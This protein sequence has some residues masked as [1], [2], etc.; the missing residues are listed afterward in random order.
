MVLGEPE[1]GAFAEAAMVSHELCGRC[2][3]LIL[4]YQLADSVWPEALAGTVDT[5]SDRTVSISGG[6]VQF[7]EC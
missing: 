7:G 2:A 1:D 3:G 6:F 4:S 5:G